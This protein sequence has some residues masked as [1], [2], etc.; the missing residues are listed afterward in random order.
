MSRAEP[1]GLDLEF[2]VDTGYMY[3]ILINSRTGISKSLGVFEGWAL[4]L[5]NDPAKQPSD[6]DAV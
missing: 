3:T 4:A 2:R 1:P 6:R 5:S